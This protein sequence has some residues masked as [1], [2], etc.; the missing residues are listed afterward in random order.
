MLRRIVQEAVAHSC[1]RNGEIDDI[2]H[3]RQN[4]RL[5]AGLI[6]PVSSKQ[7]RRMNDEG[8]METVFKTAAFP[9]AQRMVGQNK[10]YGVFILSLF[11]QAFDKLSDCPVRV[12]SHIQI[13][14]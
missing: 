8:N 14:H 7:R 10:K 4:I 12:I 11:F 1:I 2:Q 9:P 5:A 13:E 6:N 3:R